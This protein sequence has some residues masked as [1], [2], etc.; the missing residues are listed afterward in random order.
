MSAGPT[1]TPPAATSEVARRVAGPPPYGVRVAILH[2]ALEADWRAAQDVGAYTVSTLGHSLDEVGFVHACEDVEQL[3]GVAAA[4]YA[5]VT[6]P[7]VVL[8]IDESSVGS[9]VVREV[10]DGADQA[11]P[12]VYGPVPVA[13]VVEVSPWPL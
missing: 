6:E 11:Y 3:R 12:H 4:A 9:S 1:G 10:P 7:L 8:T 13:A 2:L 5:E